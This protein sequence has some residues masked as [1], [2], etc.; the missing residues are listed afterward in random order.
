MSLKRGRRLNGFQVV[1]SAFVALV[2][3]GTAL[4]LLPGTHTAAG[5]HAAA[6]TGHRLV[7]DLF[8]AASAVCVTGLVT[9]DPGTDYTPFGQ[10]ILL[11]LFQVGGFGY[12][13][14]FTLGV[15]LV[16]KRLSMRDQLAYQS[17]EG[18]SGLGGLA[19]HVRRI[20]VFTLLLEGCGTALL[21]ACWIPQYG[22]GQGLWLGLFHALSA[23]N[24]AGFTLFPGGAMALQAQPVALLGISALVIAGSL[25]FPVLHEVR[26]RLA[27][28]AHG[29]GPNWSP[30]AAVVLPLTAALLLSSTVAFWLF[31]HG[32]PQTLGPLSAGLQV[33]NAFFM[34]VQPRSAGFNSVDLAQ[35]SSPSI[36]ITLFLIFI[37]GGP[38]G[39]A[40][41]IKLT[42]FAIVLAAC[43]AALRGER[44][45]NLPGLRRRVDERLVRKAFTVVV[46]SLG[47]ILAMTT[48]IDAL[49]P[50]AFLPV[51]FEVV[52][53]FC[54]CGLSLGITAKLGITSKVLLVA[55]MLVGRVGLLAVL[56]SVFT[57][58]RPSALRYGEEPLMIG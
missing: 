9:V 42:T 35:L 27:R 8:M 33:V 34:A 48:L 31:E 47:Y 40:G 3:L 21:A 16:G 28:K 52:S 46:L 53:A 51:L 10:A 18:L 45:V 23:F 29:I 44:D 36:M 26:C 50:H 5:A 20:F 6:T 37:G 15:L 24:H 7:D 1:V 19:H 2:S 14:L 25:G 41:G 11:M 30:L 4:L 57:V 38:G 43:W 17:T 58:R 55:T 32:N 22:L 39:T 49:E 12:M 54:T 13:T 56:L